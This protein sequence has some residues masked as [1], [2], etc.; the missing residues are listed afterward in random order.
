[1]FPN[2]KICA[3]SSPK[4]NENMGLVQWLIPSKREALSSSTSAAKRK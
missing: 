1:M 3:L 4:E 2:I